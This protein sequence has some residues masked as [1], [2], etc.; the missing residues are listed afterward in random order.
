M[1]VCPRCSA[2]LAA[3]VQFCSQCGNSIS[4]SSVPYNPL[5]P[6][7]TI[8]YAGLQET[9][10]KAI[11][12]LICGILGVIILPFFASVPAVILGHLSLSEIRK[13]AGR[14]KGKG[15]AIAGLV[16]GY[17]SV[18]LI[19]FILIIAAIAIPNLLRARMAS[20]EMTAIATLRTYNAAI[21][22]YAT[23][24]QNVGFP[25]DVSDM[26]PGD[27]SCK[28][29]NLLRGELAGLARPSLT[30][31]GYQ[32]S[33]SPGST[34]TAGRVVTYSITADPVTENT[35]GMRHFFTDESG[36]I[37]QNSGAPATVDSPPATILK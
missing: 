24:C 14:L 32:F 3:G 2:N 15:M 8:A 9:S 18:A 33:Y 27:G 25:A 34:D 13:S 6:S 29:A 36:V 10:G 1:P 7:G 12:S 17:I 11:G 19:P 35:S 21:V 30:R 5:N 23:N 20:N 28:S 22:A 16:M 37:R 31:T 4:S 26:G